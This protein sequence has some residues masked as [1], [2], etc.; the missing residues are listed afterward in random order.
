MRNIRTCA[1]FALVAL[2]GCG[3][4]LGQITAHYGGPRDWS[5]GPFHM[6]SVGF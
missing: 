4:Q 3:Y 2:T 5:V 6:F 1:L